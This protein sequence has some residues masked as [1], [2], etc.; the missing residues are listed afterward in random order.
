MP[1]IA[2]GRR[3][4]PGV[5]LQELT[6]MLIFTMRRP[7]K[8][9]IRK[10]AAKVYRHE[11]RES[12]SPARSPRRLRRKVVSSM[13]AGQPF[14]KESSLALAK[15]SY[16]DMGSA[17]A[18]SRVAPRERTWPGRA[19]VFV[20]PAE[21]RHRGFAGFAL[22]LGPGIPGQRGA[23]HLS[24]AP[25]VSRPR[26]GSRRQPQVASA[27]GE[28]VACAGRGCCADCTGYRG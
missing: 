5:A 24:S 10:N 22:R 15:R 21:P 13:G 17:L 25:E 14:R 1:R 3:S 28:R 26:P 18:T 6:R 4:Q 11:G 20:K 2:A 8:S 7:M 19:V 12:S 27:N 23:L 16:H 9:G